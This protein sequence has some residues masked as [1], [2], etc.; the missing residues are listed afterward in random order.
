MRVM[1]ENEG[2]AIN[3]KKDISDSGERSSLKSKGG[4]KQVEEMDEV[5]IL[6]NPRSVSVDCQDDD[7][8]MNEMNAKDCTD[9]DGDDQS[10]L[11]FRMKEKLHSLTGNIRHRTS[12]VAQVSN[13]FFKILDK[14]QMVDEIMRESD[15]DDGGEKSLEDIETRKEHRPSL[16]S[17]IGLQVSP[18][19]KCFEILLKTAL[20]SNKFFEYL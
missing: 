7:M 20:K 2:S 19:N 3:R 16:M 10:R 6:G 1:K 13:I 14:T 15:D 18:S 11:S 17:L 5:S 4:R 9:G 8:Q 12:Q